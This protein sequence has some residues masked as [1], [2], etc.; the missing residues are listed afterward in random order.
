MY[1]LEPIIYC[2]PHDGLKYRQ[3]F[4]SKLNGN[5]LAPLE[6]SEDFTYLGKKRKN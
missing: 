2:R 5:Q 6:L 1:I 4:V 3:K